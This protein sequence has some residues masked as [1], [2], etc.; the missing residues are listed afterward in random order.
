MT[1][2]VRAPTYIRAFDRRRMVEVSPNRCVNLSAARRLG[3]VAKL[4][5]RHTP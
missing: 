4:R 1:K 2:S 3:L 5:R